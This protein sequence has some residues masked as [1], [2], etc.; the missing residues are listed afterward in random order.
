MGLGENAVDD[1]NSLDVMQGVY[2]YLMSYYS[3]YLSHA[4][5]GDIS[6]VAVDGNFKLLPSI[7]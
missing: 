4:V 2:G 1:V 6:T 7:A 5:N 3:E